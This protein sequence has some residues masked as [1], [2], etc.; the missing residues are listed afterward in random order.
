MVKKSSGKA[1]KAVVKKP[2]STKARKAES[3]AAVA[4][5]PVAVVE[6]P[7]FAGLQ[8]WNLVLAGV[9]AAQAVALLV[10]GTSKS[11]PVFAGFLA[12]DPL[13]SAARGETVLTFAIHHLF[14]INLAYLLATILA[15]AAA[16]HLLAATA[17]RPKYEAG[18]EVGVSRRRW[19]T[20]ALTGAL[21]WTAVALLVG[22]QD[23]A[24]LLGGAS[25]LV[26]G[27]L[28]A[29]AC[30]RQ[31][32]GKLPIVVASVAAGVAW[33]LCGLYVLAGL[34]YG[35]ALSVYVYI[36][37]G[38]SMLAT[39]A[40]A[41][42]LWLSKRQT[43]RWASYLFAEQTYLVISAVWLTALAWLGFAAMAV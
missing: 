39:G 3:V 37:F 1:G 28:G 17:Q 5:E 29:Y 9:L 18:L 21:G 4:V 26:V 13:Q 12:R 36:A 6:K 8:K 35:S 19:L 22:V 32:G 38:V 30:E 43:S 15:I 34:L 14:D 11:Y 40:I 2:K 27:A 20:Y 24:L 25:L 33:L 10:F 42:G 31:T 41:A 7:S 16:A 23:V